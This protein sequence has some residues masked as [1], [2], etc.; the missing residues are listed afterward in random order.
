MLEIIG[1]ADLS[2]KQPYDPVLLAHQARVAGFNRGSR[3]IHVAIDDGPPLCPH[4]KVEMSRATIPDGYKN[5]GREVWLC[6]RFNA[7]GQWELAK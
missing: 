4:H 3:Y 1:N 7:C 2:D 5:A 6:P